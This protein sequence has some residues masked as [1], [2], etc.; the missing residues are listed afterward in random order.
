M[1]DLK[2]K[3][4]EDLKLNPSSKNLEYYLKCYS[5]PKYFIDLLFKTFDPKVDNKASPVLILNNK[6]YISVNLLIDNWEDLFGFQCCF[7]SAEIKKYVW[8]ISK[9]SQFVQYSFGPKYRVLT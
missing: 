6:K 9:A 1:I 5:G 3:Y 8:S 2:L 7:N 4:P